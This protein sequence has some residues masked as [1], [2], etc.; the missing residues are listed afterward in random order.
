MNTLL[1]IALTA[2]AVLI[3]AN[4]LPG[5]AVSGY[6]GAIIVAIVLAILRLFVKPLLILFTLPLTIITLGL[7]LFVINAV[8][9]L[10][11]SEMLDGFRVDG[12][13]WAVLFSILLSFLQAFVN[14]LVK[15]EKPKA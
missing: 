11:A 10:L 4:V 9:V 15:E 1:K 5:V 14:S 6:W 7:F 8:I 2:G 12:F 13:W 3:L